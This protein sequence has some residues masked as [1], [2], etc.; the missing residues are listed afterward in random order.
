[1]CSSVIKDRLIY[2]SRYWQYEQIIN[3][4][5][6][7][8]FETFA[9]GELSDRCNRTVE[10]IYRNHLFE[11]CDNTS[12]TI[13]AEQICREACDVMV[14]QHCKEEFRRGYIRRGYRLNK[15]LNWIHLLNCI[16]LPRRNGGTIPECYYPRELEGTLLSFV[17][18]RI[19]T[20]K[21]LISQY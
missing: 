3:E 9:K 20:D 12:S 13:L 15:V 10:L 14:K 2:S 8:D 19:T 17:K 18:K 5:S 16:K 6:R 4:K 7:S 1:M 11:R 21:H